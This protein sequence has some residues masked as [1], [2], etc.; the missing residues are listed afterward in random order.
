MANAFLNRCHFYIILFY[1]VICKYFFQYIN[2]MSIFYS[3][4]PTWGPYLL[5]ITTIKPVKRNLSITDSFFKQKRNHGLYKGTTIKLHL[6]K[7]RTLS[8]QI[9]IFLYYFF[10][11]CFTQMRFQKGNVEG[12]MTLKISEDQDNFEWVIY[13]SLQNEKSHGQII[14]HLSRKTADSLT[15]LLQ[16]SQIIQPDYP[17][18][19]VINE[20]W[21]VSRE[22]HYG[23][24]TECNLMFLFQSNVKSNVSDHKNEWNI[25]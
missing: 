9:V 5:S 25:V 14:T 10:S 11:F 12:I 23:W 19:L 1:V 21:G 3:F 16:T 15:S 6:L 2:Y 17:S 13:F 4:F 20:K 18:Q 24:N 7:L 22:R 8:W